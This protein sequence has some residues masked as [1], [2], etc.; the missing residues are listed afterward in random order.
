MWDL[1]Y[2][3]DA[4]AEE[5][6]LPPREQLATTNAVDKLRVAGPSLSFPHQSAVRGATVRELRPRGGR[7]PW[8][9]FYRRVGNQFVVGATG[10][11]ATVSPK[12]FQKAVGFAESRLN[13]IAQEGSDEAFRHA[14]S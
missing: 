3:P 14:H 7:S 1:R 11:E 6:A 12:G 13:Q 5:D 4:K 9:A 8:R 10:L 2:H